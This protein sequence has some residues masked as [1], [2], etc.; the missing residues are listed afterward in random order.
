MA[1]APKFTF[2]SEKDVK[3][4]VKALLEHHKW[5]WWMPAAN[6]YG[7]QGVADICAFRGGVFMA[8]ETKFKKNVPSTLQLQFL[9]SI[10]AQS[11]FGFVI[12]EQNVGWFDVFL[13]AFD[14]AALAEA[15]KRV[16]PHEEGAA[17]LN[18]LQA[19]THMIPPVLAPTTDAT[20]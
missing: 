7:Q 6:G 12:N 9:R 17:M 15:E 3:K 5:F 8:L 14:K 4:R 19:L 13:Q 2:N 11:G 16:V 1:N 10:Q 18:A 20:Q